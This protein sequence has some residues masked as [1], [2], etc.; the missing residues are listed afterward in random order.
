MS[1]PFKFLDSYEA[2]DKAIFFGR[3]EEIEALYKLVFQTKLLL[4][5]GQSGTGKTSL[6][7]CGLSNRFKTSD[8]FELFVR[9][10]D[11]LNQSLTREIRRHA[12]TPI[13]DAAGVVEAIRSLYLDHLRP[14]YL[15][16]DQFEEL[17]ILGQPEEQRAFIAS[18][19]ALLASDVSCKIVISM[20]E[21]YIA[22]LHDFERTVPTLFNKRLRVEPM[23]MRNV[24]QVIVGTTGALGISLESGEATAQAIIDNLS[25]GR[26][27]V[28]LSYLQV[29]LDKLYRGA[30]PDG[31]DSASGAIVFTDHLVQQTGAL[32]DVMADFLEEQTAAIQKEIADRSP[33]I[34]ADAVQRVL[35]EFATLDGTKQPMSRDELASRLPALSLFIDACL[36]AFESKRIVR[37]ADGL[38]EL[39]HDT[40]AGRIADKRSGER[41]SLLKVQKLIKDRLAAFPQTHTFLNGEELAVARPFLAQ[42]GL[43]ADEAGFVKKSA[44]KVRRRRVVTVAGTASMLLILAG[45]ALWARIE[46]QR[47]RNAI[48]MAS[49][50]TNDLSFTIV[51]R[52]KEITKTQDIR[53]E[54]LAKAGEVNDQLAGTGDSA[55]GSAPFWRDILE[56]DIALQRG[57]DARSKFNKSVEGARLNARRNPRDIVWQRNLSVALG[58]LGSLDLVANPDAALRHFSE[59]LE[60]DKALV[61]SD[62]SKLEFKRDLSVSHGQLGDLE[63]GRGH[64]DQALQHYVQSLALA[65]ELAGND[66]QNQDWQDDLSLNYS[67]IGELELLRQ[68]HARANE[69]YTKSTQ[70]LAQL[71]KADPTNFSWQEKLARGYKSLGE[72]ALEQDQPQEA[73]A[74]SD[75]AL[76]MAHAWAEKDPD[77]LKTRELLSET[78][79][80]RAEIALAVGDVKGARVHALQSLEAARRLYKTDPKNDSWQRLLSLSHRQ[81]SDA[82]MGRCDFKAARESALQSVD[83]AQRLFENNPPNKTEYAFDLYAVKMKLGV[84]ERQDRQVKAARQATDSALAVAQRLSDQLPDDPQLKEDIETLRRTS[85]EIDRGVPTAPLAGCPSSR[86][87]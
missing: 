69:M 1:S 52:L 60:I 87:R 84:I 27:G 22:M 16:F 21:E 70:V 30:A 66:P 12:Q 73:L 64:D 5:Y 81:I 14:V 8:W 79:R 19:A 4:V 86:A 15:I 54:L 82:E 2:R 25:E 33:G 6:I 20:R 28:P 61:K 80:Q 76:A 68:H 50:V 7:Q 83:I 24:Q 9:R 42:L 62:P 38:Y 3:D 59:A 46:E 58:R 17:F 29:Y 55:K 75:Q 63:K 48:A 11:D 41:K 35:E 10:K 57:G 13:A 37:N 53:R 77:N 18:I 56:G 49:N 40:L 65:E 74:P 31:Q 36:V 32:G 72:V 26:S 47:A 34:P 71:V 43:S 67:R 51:D 23:N 44:E 78:H 39:A 45:L 85:A